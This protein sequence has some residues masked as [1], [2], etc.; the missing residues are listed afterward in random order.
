MKRIKKLKRL[1]EELE[2][3]KRHFTLL[4]SL[5]HTTETSLTKANVKVEVTL[6]LSF[7]LF[8]KLSS[9]DESDSSL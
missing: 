9:K 5:Y 1:K 7:T 6:L 2:L 3:K 4:A 8:I